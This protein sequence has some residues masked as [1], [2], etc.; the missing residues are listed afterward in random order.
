MPLG[1]NNRLMPIMNNMFLILPMT[2]YLML[3]WAKSYGNRWINYTTIIIFSSFFMIKNCLIGKQFRFRGNGYQKKRTS[4]IETIQRLKGMY[5][6]LARA[7]DL[8]EL[9]EFLLQ[10][11][12][13]K[14]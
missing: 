5:T 8:E 1:S 6:N 10:V 13:K 2:G 4:K 3:K 14:N 12:Q 9:Q 7:E 11:D